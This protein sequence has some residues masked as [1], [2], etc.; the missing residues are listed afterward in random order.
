VAPC[1]ATGAVALQSG[2]SKESL[3]VRLVSDQKKPSPEG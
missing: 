1:P 3:L 2:G